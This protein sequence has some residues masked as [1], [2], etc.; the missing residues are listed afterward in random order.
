MVFD[1]IE[2]QGFFFFLTTYMQVPWKD[3]VT[4]NPCLNKKRHVRSSKLEGLVRKC[5]RNS[6][7]QLRFWI[8]EKCFNY[9]NRIFEI[10]NMCQF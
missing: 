7:W 8:E 4:V 9:S 2:E 1:I 6:Y 3:W 5:E 10:M